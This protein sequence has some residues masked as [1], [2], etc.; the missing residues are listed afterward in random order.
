MY[1]C[2]T[3]I[4]IASPP[5]RG[6]KTTS[7][8]LGKRLEAQYIQAGGDD[9][10]GTLVFSTIPKKLDGKKIPRHRPF[11]VGFFSPGEKQR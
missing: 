2:R 11:P 10:I 6:R 7:K 1:A 3:T 8:R 5:F 4:H 9:E